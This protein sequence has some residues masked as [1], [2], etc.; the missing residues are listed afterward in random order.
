MAAMILLTVAPGPVIFIWTQNK[1]PKTMRMTITLSRRPITAC[2]SYAKKQ[3]ELEEIT[4]RSFPKIF[5]EF[6]SL[7]RKWRTFS[8][9]HI[10]KLKRLKMV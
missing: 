7:A 6:S 3:S 1:Q 9:A 5:Q 8:M 10:K 2:T 4:K